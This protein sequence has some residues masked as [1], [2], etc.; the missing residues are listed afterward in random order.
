[1]SRHGNPF[2][3]VIKWVLTLV[4]LGFLAGTFVASHTTDGDGQRSARGELAKRLRHLA[5]KVE[6]MSDESDDTAEGDA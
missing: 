5:D 6:Q 1:M 2:E 3:R 4:G